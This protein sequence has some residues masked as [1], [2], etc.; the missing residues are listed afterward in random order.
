MK[1]RKPDNANPNLLTG[2]LDDSDQEHRVCQEGQ[3]LPRQHRGPGYP[4]LQ[5]GVEPNFIMTNIERMSVI[6]IQ[7]PP[8]SSISSHD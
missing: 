7:V 2:Q 8:E 3:V 1:S 5:V 4:C 6:Q